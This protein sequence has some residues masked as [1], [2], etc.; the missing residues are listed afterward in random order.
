MVTVHKVQIR[1]NVLQ[2]DIV[3]VHALLVILVMV[4]LTVEQ[5]VVRLNQNY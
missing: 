2:L 3:L 4:L 1:Y 5:K